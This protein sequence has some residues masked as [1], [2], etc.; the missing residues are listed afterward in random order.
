M[1]AQPSH[2]FRDACLSYMGVAAFLPNVVRRDFISW[3]AVVL[4]ALALTQVS[5]ALQAIGSVV[6]AI[7]V[8]FDHVRVRRQL[9]AISRAGQ[10]LA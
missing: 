8:L 9:R 4:A 2:A 1:P 5:F 3:G 6:T 10:R 7:I